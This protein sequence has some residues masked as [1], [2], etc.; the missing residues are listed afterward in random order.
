MLFLLHTFTY[1]EDSLTLSL[2]VAVVFVF[3][4]SADHDQT[5]WILAMICAVCYSF[6][7]Y[8]SNW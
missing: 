4:T 6:S 7:Y 3:A 2:L 8:P 5:S 1:N